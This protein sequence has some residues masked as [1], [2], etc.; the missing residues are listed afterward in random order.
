MSTFGE[1]SKKKK[2]RKAENKVE[3]EDG[4]DVGDN[5][6]TEMPPL[7]RKKTAVPLRIE[8]RAFNLAPPGGGKFG[9]QLCWGWSWGWGWQ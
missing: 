4:G 8:L 3:L 6:E 1:L 9:R 5:Y 2:I 7:E